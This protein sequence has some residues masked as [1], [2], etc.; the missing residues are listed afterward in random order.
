MSCPNC[1]TPKTPGARYCPQ[2]GVR[3]SLPTDGLKAGDRRVV[4]ALF[5][6]LVGYTRLVD[7]LDP[8]EV[9]LRVD[10]ALATL[11]GAV[12]KFG[13]TVEKFIG[14]ALL[15]IFG[16]PAAHDDDA[17]RACMCA[18]EMQG[19]LSWSATGQ[20]MPL[21]LRIGIATGEVVAAQR[22]LAGTRSVALTGD[23]LT[24]AARLQQLAE[25]GEILID[26]VTAA[27]ADPRIGYVQVGERVLRGQAR[28]VVVNRLRG[29]RRILR[30]PGAGSTPLVGRDAEKALLASV[31]ARTVAT[32][33]GGTVL[34]RG[35][36]GIG[37]SRLLAEMEEEARAAGMSW[38][39]IDHPPHRKDAPYHTARALVDALADEAGVRAGILARRAVGSDMDEETARLLFGAAAMIARDS[40]MQLLPEEGW[41][42][43]FTGLSD[44]A[45]LITGVKLVV[46]WFTSGLV[47][48]HPRC[49]VMDDYHW[50]DPSS[51]MMLAEMIRLSSELPLV[52]LTGTRPPLLPEWVSMPHVRVV[53]LGGLDQGAT[54]QLGTAVAGASLEAESARWLYDRTAGNAL[55]VGEVVRTLRDGGRLESVEGG[56]R[57][58]RGVGR[59]NVPL[60]LKALLGARI[61]ALPEAQRVVLEVASV[62]GTTFSEEL[63]RELCGDCEAGDHLDRLAAAGILTRV[64]TPDDGASGGSGEPRWRFRHALFLDAAYGRLLGERRR[65]LHGAL[66]DIL[67]RSEPHTDAGEMARHRVAA[68][69]VERALP[70]LE[71]AAREAAA[72]G[73][74][75]EAETFL[76]TAAGLRS[77]RSAAFS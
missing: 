22:D 69:D 3:L 49:V 45:E 34:V 51:Q 5:A 48:N 31:I 66:A 58:D 60:S 6:D 43:R 38:T 33:H 63:L 15:V 62:I 59:R 71:Q 42:E 2:C 1:A 55:F 44:P 46:A 77:Q 35:E 57:I 8:E 16:T 37:K 53:E 68:G 70:L 56:L 36:A 40:E 10:V 41:D 26:A 54:E 29:E 47:A 17:V 20:D 21:Q 30:H 64:D 52:V 24:T 65:A 14:D 13:G 4:S 18:L 11:S 25:P 27:A 67:E 74:M 19:A 72:M 9:R 7:E 12:V 61:D 28:P 50:M 32:G 73:A 23:P 76:R 75:T 39:W